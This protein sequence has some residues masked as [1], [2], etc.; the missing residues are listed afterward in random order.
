MSAASASCWIGSGSRKFRAVYVDQLTDA[1]EL[2]GRRAAASVSAALE[3][4]VWDGA[5]VRWV[6]YRLGLVPADTQTTE[7]ERACLARHAAGRRSLVE[8]GVMH[9][10]T[11]ALLGASWRP[12]AS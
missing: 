11:T 12:T 9:G 7:A 1:D 2:I 3:V 4:I 10:V 5:A 8:L 6:R